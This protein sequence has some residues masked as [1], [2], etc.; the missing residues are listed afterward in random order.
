M[1]DSARPL[2]P[3]EEGQIAFA[4][5]LPFHQNPYDPVTQAVEYDRWENGYWMASVKD[6]GN[7]PDNDQESA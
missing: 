2:S 6:A 4:N 5:G 1:A 7:E 3:Y